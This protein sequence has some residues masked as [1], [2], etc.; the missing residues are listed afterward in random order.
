MQKKLL[1]LILNIFLICPVAF[2]II[3]GRIDGFNAPK[4][5]DNSYYMTIPEGAFLKAILQSNI[6]TETNLKYDTVTA[7]IPANFYAMNSICIPKDSIFEGEIV[8]LELP[9]KG[10]HGLFQVKFNKLIMADGKVLP[11]NSSLWVQ[12][13]TQVGGSPSQLGEV[14][15]IPHRVQGLSPIGYL[16]IQRTGE[17]LKGKDVSIK[18]GSEILIKLDEKLN[19]KL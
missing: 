12:G 8:K 19:I 5:R 16:N 9:K 6:S 11:I 10:R 1:L 14:K 15:V 2:G 4:I 3:E 17:Y 7:I 13:S 18:A